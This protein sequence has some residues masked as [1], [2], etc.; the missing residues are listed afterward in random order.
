[1]GA[2]GR[3][4]WL[5]EDAPEDDYE[6]IGG[7]QAQRSSG[8]RT[9]PTTMTTSRD[10]PDGEHLRHGAEMAAAAAALTDAQQ[11]KLHP[12]GHPDPMPMSQK[13]TTASPQG[14]V[15]N[16]RLQQ[17]RGVVSTDGSKDKTSMTRLKNIFR[18][19]HGGK[20][21][22]S[23]VDHTEDD[24]ARLTKPISSPLLTPGK[25][26]HQPHSVAAFAGPV[27][28]GTAAP[29]AVPNVRGLA[30]R[31]LPRPPQPPKPADSAIERLQVAVPAGHLSIVYPDS[32]MSKADTLGRTSTDSALKRQSVGA[33]A[34]RSG[35]AYLVNPDKYEEFDQFDEDDGY[36][37]AD[38]H[39][40]AS[41]TTTLRPTSQM[42]PQSYGRRV[43]QPGYL[44]SSATFGQSNEGRRVYGMQR[45]AD[46]DTQIDRRLPA[47]TYV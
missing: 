23:N 45:M 2:G 20:S 29:A 13:P 30:R 41:N 3:A 16:I 5:S 7:K 8:A 10:A 27:F 17:Q 46:S 19:G 24:G 12:I 25:F 21:K 14:Q 42:H 36:N 9:H 26:Q 43:A 33:A 22:G 11:Q 44:T 47:D 35:H 39:A 18:M 28:S 31:D 38:L 37:G 34:G 1:M 40:A 15:S 4:T 6:F 32:P